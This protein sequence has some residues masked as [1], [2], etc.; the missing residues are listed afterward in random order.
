MNKPKIIGYFTASG[1]LEDID[2]TVNQALK[3]GWRP[4]GAPFLIP[5]RD[6]F[7]V[8]ALVKCEKEE[9]EKE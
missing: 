5:S 2:K 3:D 8:Q 4:W 7:I 9:P 6:Y 1:T